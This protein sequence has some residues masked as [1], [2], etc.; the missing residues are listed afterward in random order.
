MSDYVVTEIVF[1]N[2]DNKTIEYYIKSGD[3]KD[4]AGGVGIQELGSIFVKEI[5]GDY[6]NVVGLPISTVSKY[7]IKYFGINLMER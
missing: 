6:H 7:L 5:R 4:K 2:L 1:D 3:W